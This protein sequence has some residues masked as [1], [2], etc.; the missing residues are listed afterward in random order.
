MLTL[1]DTLIATTQCR[2]RTGVY[3]DALW[4]PAPAP[5]DLRHAMQLTARC[6]STAF[7]LEKRGGK[8]GTWRRN[9]IDHDL[10]VLAV[11][12]ILALSLAGSASARTVVRPRYGWS[13]RF[14]RGRFRHHRSSGGRAAFP[15]PPSGYRR[16]AARGEGILGSELAAKSPPD[17]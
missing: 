5:H 8:S 6:A 7:V 4:L 16:D 10:R 1:R 14:P 13:S 9:R 12:S 17:V 11:W 3:M 15:R 2:G